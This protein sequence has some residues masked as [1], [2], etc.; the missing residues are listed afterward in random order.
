MDET[1]ERNRLPGFLFRL[2]VIWCVIILLGSFLL[3]LRGNPSPAVITVMPETPR[4]GEPLL[5][6]LKLDNPQ[7][8]SQ[9]VNLQFYADGTLMQTGQTAIAPLS[10]KTYQYDYPS[11]VNIGQQITFLARTESG[12]RTSEQSVS[13]PPFAPEVCSSFISFASFSTSVMSSMVTTVYYQQNFTTAT[14][15]NTGLVVSVVLIVLLIFLELAGAAS[16]DSASVEASGGLAFLQRLRVRYS[17]L[18]WILLIIFIGIVITK[19]VMILAA[20]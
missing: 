17:I 9:V 10:G 12:G 2:A 20:G 13:I 11:P 14:T 6:T 1:K 15:M 5:I 8:F 16:E 4:Q 7:P 3:T 18:T 19:I